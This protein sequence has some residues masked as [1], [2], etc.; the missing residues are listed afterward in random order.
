MFEG[1]IGQ[2]IDRLKALAAARARLEAEAADLLGE[3]ERSGIHRGDGHASAK[4]MARHV[5]R[6]S[7]ATAGCRERVAR[8]M[9]DLPVLADAFRAG[10]IGVDQMHLLGRVHANARVRPFMPDAQDWF[11]K[12]ARRLSC[13]REV[14]VDQDRG[15]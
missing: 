15:C 1:E 2:V 14:Q 4:V 7:G 8:M 3:I 11:L 10:T 6:L 5:G 13:R 12:Q 9:R